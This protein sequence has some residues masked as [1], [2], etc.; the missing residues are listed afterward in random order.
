MTDELGP[1]LYWAP[2]SYLVLAPRGLWVALSGA[3]RRSILRHELAHLRRWDLQK[4][5]L[6]RLAA[7]PQ[8]FNPLVRLAVRRF[9][10]AGEWAC[11][12]AAGM[13]P[14]ARLAFA[15]VLLRAA[16]GVVG[17]KKAALPGAR[18]LR[19]GVLGR[20]V[21]RL[22]Y[23]RFK[24]ESMMKKFTLY[25]VFIAATLLQWVRVERVAGEDES[26]A[27]SRIE[28][29]QMV[30]AWADLEKPDSTALMA[31]NEASEYVIEPPDVLTIEF[32]YKTK[33]AAPVPPKNDSSET[34]RLIR[35]KPQE[36][37][38]AADGTINLDGSPVYVAGLTLKEAHKAIA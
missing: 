20:R 38:V 30:E 23:P 15:R 27:R 25:L 17:V 24:E 32:D 19:G 7:L 29:R 21:R 1:L 12:E 33:L 3:E 36:Y 18:G 5:L 14:A 9:D 2:W 8:W 10:E 31:A 34:T 6:I 28:E 16:E 11:D 4:S 37:L 13:N 22:V 26:G 35:V